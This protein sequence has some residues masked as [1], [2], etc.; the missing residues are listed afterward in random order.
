VQGWMMAQLAAPLAARGIRP[1]AWEEA[2]RGGQGGI[3]H[4]ALLFSWSGQG[5]GIS[6][7]RAGYDV[8]MCPAQNVYF[9]MAHTGDPDDWGAQWAAFVSLEETVNWR[10]IPEGAE[11]V[12]HK[13]V[14]V[15]GAYWS[16]FTTEDR[17]M[18]PMIAPRILGLAAKAWEV[19]EVTDGLALRALSG[20]YG[21]FFDAI[22]WVRHR[23]P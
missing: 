5:P 7:A 3:G 19:A 21:A 12:A 4:D 14:G 11:D 10:V 9:D 20:P 16:E 6:A 18:E 22:G 8:V 15:E 1:A 23:S 2:A 13:I 17:Q